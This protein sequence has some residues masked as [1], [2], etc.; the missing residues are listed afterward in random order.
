MTGWSIEA[1]DL[2]IAATDHC[3]VSNLSLQVGPGDITCLLGPNGCG[4]TTTLR[5]FAKLIDPLKGSL[6]ING[7]PLDQLKRKDI[8]KTLGMVTQNQDDAFPTT[9]LQTCLVGRHPHIDFWQWESK[10]DMDIAREALSTMGL[11]RLE[12]RSTQT[13]SGGERQRLALATLLT[14]DPD[15]IL[16]DEP[17]NHLDPRHQILTIEL[18]KQLAQQG[19]CILTA[20]HDINMAMA[21]SNKAL[22]LFGDGDWMFG[23]IEEVLTPDN[24]NRLYGARFVKVEKDDRSY[25]FLG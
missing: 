7:H 9:V 6:L 11:D 23:E 24:L 21:V 1:R 4:K 18:I 15:I 19:K 3:L 17:T 5:T 22:L 10:S 25:F 16:L 12:Q 2:D 20:F 13:L 14:Q 8:A